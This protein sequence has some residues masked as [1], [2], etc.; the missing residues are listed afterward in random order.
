MAGWISSKLKVAET[1]LQQIDHQ[2]AESLGKNDKPRSDD[3]SI[4][5]SRKSTEVVPL[6]DQLKKKKNKD[7]TTQ[8][9]DLI[10]KSRNDRN[11]IEISSNKISVNR[12][13]VEEVG[14]LAV[15]PPPKSGLTDS[16]WTQLLS[17]PSQPTS[18]VVTSGNGV[19]GIHGLQKDGQT[20][21]RSGSNLSAL[22]GKRNQKG[23][24]S[25]LRTLKKP[26]VLSENKVNGGRRRDGEDSRIVQGISR[27]ELGSGG[28][29]SE[30][31]E[32]DRKDA[33]PSLVVEN[34]YKANEERNGVSEETHGDMGHLHS[35]EVTSVDTV[36]QSTDRDSLVEMAS[37]TADGVSDLKMGNGNDDHNR[38]RSSIGGINERSAGPR[39]SRTL[40]RDSPSISNRG[41]DSETEST[42]TS[43]SESERE[44][45]ER[46]RRAAQI[47]VEKAA[48]R[49]IEAI[50][51]REN[52][53]AR[54]E[55]EKQSLEK[56]LEER[57]KQQ[58]Q[59][60]SEL[61]NTMM[62]TMEAVDL[63]KQKHNNTRMEALGR[64]AKLETT[65]ADLARSLAAAQWNLEVE[66]NRVAELRQQ[67][68]LKEANHEELRR[69]ISTIHDTGNQFVAPKGV[70]LEREILEAEYSFVTEKIGRLEEKAKTLETN[71]EMTRKDIENPT[72]VE[73]E[74]KRRLGQLTDHL[75]QKQ[76]Q[77]EA[78]SSEKATHLL[79]IEAVSRLLDENK[80]K[81]NATDIESG[82][83]EFSNSKLRPLFKERMQ[84]GRQHLGSLVR[85][86]D[87]I[88]CAGAVFLRRNSTARLWSF[89]Y[90]VCLHF[91]VVYILM[92]HSP[93]S[94][95]ARSG[96]V[97]SLENINN[98]GGV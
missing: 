43:D 84:S 36:P 63:E 5:T 82:I 2:A 39:R 79:R 52:M 55:G 66:V 29:E 11:S 42:S 80:S 15:N 74:L 23:K 40:K 30:V 21:G 27:A 3:L 17:A 16:D 90:L 14:A 10:G 7:K 20:Q 6:K 31:R 98:T 51:E 37:E 26:G 64:L 86:L 9:N 57:A 18:P 76:A 97:I 41:S 34:K 56:I 25:G 61:Q 50:K 65:N 69:K 71:I 60:A 70:E 77:V 75:I 91:W 19:T 33:S 72:E 59:E 28:N 53:V 88:F 46:K 48:A 68:D 89:V 12:D 78:L 45:E 62:E 54:L 35:K 95:E 67:F 44:R 47:L 81:L 13:R 92:S 58:A 32:S 22:E 93:V 24:N 8:T 94:D 85:Q 96:A 4:E 38:F 73:V 1:L 83:W 87:S 49:A